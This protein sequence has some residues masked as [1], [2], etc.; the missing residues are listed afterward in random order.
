M[1][2]TLHKQPNH[3]TLTTSLTLGATERLENTSK[4]ILLTC[5][6]KIG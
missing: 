2:K 6:V 4:T 3:H 5:F 1:T